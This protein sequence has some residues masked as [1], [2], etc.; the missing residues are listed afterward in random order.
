MK[1]ILKFT[2]ILFLSISSVAIV[3]SVVKKPNTPAML[4]YKNVDTLIFQ[5]L[6]GL[7]NIGKE[8]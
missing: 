7:K 5:L 4:T 1:R 6:Q 8:L 2:D 3:Q